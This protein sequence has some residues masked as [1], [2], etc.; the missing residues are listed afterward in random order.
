MVV[1][2][3]IGAGDKRVMPTALGRATGANC[4]AWL[5]PSGRGAALYEVHLRVPSAEVASAKRSVQMILGR[6]PIKVAE[7]GTFADLP[8]WM[9][10]HPFQRDC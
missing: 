9:G 6:V 7:D 5:D 4:L 8:T 1:D 10:R 3:G 2:Y